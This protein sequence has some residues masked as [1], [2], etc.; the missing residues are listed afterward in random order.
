M[1]LLPKNDW[2]DGEE[3]MGRIMN[4][5]WDDRK[6]NVDIKELPDRYEVK[7]D[8]PGFEKSEIDVQYNHDILSI[9]AEHKTE[10]EAAEEGRYLRRE[11][12]TSSYRRQFVVKNID[13]DKIS[14]KFDNGVL[15]LQLPKTQREETIGKSI[16]ID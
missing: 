7:T 2:L 16:T 5:F 12:S 1:S 8:L 9:A 10:T 4:T 11:R 15:T 14:G 6:L 13:E 3:L